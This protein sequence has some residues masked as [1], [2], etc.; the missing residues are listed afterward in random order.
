MSE[1]FILIMENKIV[2]NQVITGISK[3]FKN[4]FEYFPTSINYAI[5]P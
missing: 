2:A 1:I 4:R 5:V 3:E